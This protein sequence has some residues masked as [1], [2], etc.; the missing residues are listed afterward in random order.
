MNRWFWNL[1][2]RLAG[3]KIE[4]FDINSIPKALIIVAPHTSGWDVLVGLMTRGS[5]ACKIGFMGKHT[6]FKP[7]FGFIFRWLGGVPVDRTQKTNLVDTVVEYYNS[8]DE[9]R[10]AMAP[11]GTR[12]KVDKLKTGFYFIAKKANIPIVMSSFDYEHKTVSF[13]PPFM[14]SEEIEA[15]L[16]KVWAFFKGIKG[17]H[18]EL[19]IG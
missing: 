5:L 13:S 17:Y 9:F 3:W 1:I 7:P 19:S 14:T 4:G 2:R 8:H 6:L 11:E 16:A 12:K 10:I 15:D 18:P